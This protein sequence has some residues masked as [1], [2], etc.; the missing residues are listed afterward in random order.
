MPYPPY[1][2]FSAEPIL[3]VA[4]IIRGGT[5]E[6]ELPLACKAG[7][8]LIGFGLSISPGEPDGTRP[9]VFGQVADQE[10]EDCRSV[11]KTAL[12]DAKDGP[13]GA[14]SAIDP[15]DWMLFLQLAIRMVEK[16]LKRLRDAPMGE[17]LSAAAN[18]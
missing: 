16:L 12:A 7:Y 2:P 5:L 8:A 1:P 17:D 11:L 9:V 10:L 3:D 18:V 6:T 14:E 15:E 4:R 13:V